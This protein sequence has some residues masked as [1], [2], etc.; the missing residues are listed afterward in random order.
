MVDRSVSRS[1]SCRNRSVIGSE[2][3]KIER[4]R[5]GYR[6]VFDSGYRFVSRSVNISE[7]ICEWVH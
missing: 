5:E 6:K 2:Q 3:V 7:H 1:V 4:S